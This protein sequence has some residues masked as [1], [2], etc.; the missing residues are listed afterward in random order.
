MTESATPSPEDLAAVARCKAA[1]DRIRAD[2]A[3]VIVGQGDVI[4]QV[5]IGI[6]A[7]GHAML[8]GVPGV[9]KSMLL[10]SLAEAAQLSFKRIHCTP[11]LLPGDIAGTQVIHEDTESRRHYQFQPGPLF[12][13]LLLADEINS[14]PPKTQAALLEAMHDRQISSA[15]QEYKLPE[16]FFVL[17][18]RN[19]LEQEDAY[20]LP[21]A[22]L[23]HFLLY[24]KTDYPKPAEEWEIARRF[25][26]SPPGRIAAS[27]NGEDVIE[28]QRLVERLPVNE[29]VLGYAWALVR[30]TRP[31]TQEAAAFVDKWVAH[32]AS[33]RGLLALITA[34]KARA[35][36]NGRAL[37]TIGDIQ[38]L[39]KPALR[40]RIAGNFAAQASNLDSDR[41]I[42]IL[43]EDVPADVI[44]QPP[45]G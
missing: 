20:P 37:A 26:S 36:L 27:L 43:L 14:T 5:L 41:L 4:E 1:Y 21:A 44:Y 34:A 45:T 22:Q 24:I 9:A 16:P 30:A 40:H 42:D 3:A 33:P 39:I 23:D 17:A 12:A 11:D 18:T 13:N 38:S 32:G 31:G 8:E 25:T 19:S 6:L 10:S 28:L 29:Q 7:R 35:V 2:L 15:G